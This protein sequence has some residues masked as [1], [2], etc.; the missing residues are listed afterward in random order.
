MKFLHLFQPININAVQIR[1]RLLVPPMVTN[2]CHADNTVSERLIAYHVARA[3]GGFGL[4]IVED[5]A[6]HPWGKG[7][8]AIPG[9]W[10]DRFIAGC[11]RLTAAVH[12][13]GGK[14]FAQLYHAGAQT[15]EAVI[16]IQPLAPS[17]FLH[18]LKGV[19]PRE[20]TVGEIEEIVACFGQAAHRSR[21]AGFDGVE[22]HGSHSYLVAQ[23]MSPY[24]NRR[25]DRY[26]GDL[27]GRLRFPLDI[28]ASIR[29]CAGGDFPVVMRFAGDERVSEGRGIEESRVVARLLEDA[30]YDALHVTTATTASLPY[31]APP[32]YTPVGLNVGYAEQ[33]KKVVSI[34]VITTGRISDP[35]LAEHF[36]AQ[37]CADMVGMGRASIADPE[38]P[39]KTAA[40]LLEDIRPCLACLQGCIGYLYQ[41][42]AITCTVNAEVGREQEMEL[43]PA[44]QA[45]KVLVAGGGPGGLE[46][47]RVAALR[48]HRVVL[49][50]RSPN[51]GGQLR[52]AAMPPHKQEVAHLIKY[53]LTQVGKAGVEVRL[54]TEVTPDLV[55][56]VGPDLVIVA[57]G[58]APV[59]PPLA[60][61]D[62]SNVLHAW[63]LLAGKVAAGKSAVVLGGSSV[64]C[65]TADFLAAQGKRVALVEMLE[66]VGRDLVERVRYFLLQRLQQEK[67]DIYTA[68]TVRE[69]L[70]DGVRMEHQGKMVDLRGYDHVVV[71][72]G[73]RSRSTLADQLAALGVAFTVIGDAQTPGNALEAIRQ[74]AEAGRAI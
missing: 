49:C 40:G 7:F 10:E 38:L 43:K 66:E 12:G 53:M 55:R 17:A 48:G 34:P 67:V 63:D 47:A 27:L 35:V 20:L 5:F 11:R 70:D 9:L 1:N 62:K 32:Y 61:V 68:A 65:E 45:R 71:A 39:N 59:L 3:R 28:L 2:Y 72:A 15:T 8:P 6:V 41:G 18:P 24:T 60:G 16:G 50:E 42:R 74:G 36:L 33:I 25:T 14:I 58:A 4:I 31:I 44:R 73:L 21:E 46:A 56:E 19:L 30:G 64:G 37:G 54:N 51:L 23:F 22:V 29:R 69:I 57:S 52:L 26:G 13:A